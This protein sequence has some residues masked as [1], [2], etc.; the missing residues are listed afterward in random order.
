MN[1]QEKRLTLMLDK[2]WVK[3]IAELKELQCNN[4][5]YTYKVIF[6]T[7]RQKKNHSFTF[8]D[9]EY[10]EHTIGFI[11]KTYNQN[12]EVKER[13]V[14]KDIDIISLEIKEKY[15]LKDYVFN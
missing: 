10:N 13:E 2:E 15:N 4:D 12:D 9:I 8:Q 7:E 1:E 3:T 14:L 5:K 6:K 11:F